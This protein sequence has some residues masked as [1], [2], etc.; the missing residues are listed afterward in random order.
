MLPLGEVP[1]PS[2][3]GRIASRQAETGGRPC[4]AVGPSVVRSPGHDPAPSHTPTRARY[5]LP[6]SSPA[7]VEFAGLPSGGCAWP[8]HQPR[9]RCGWRPDDGPAQ[10]H[11][12]LARPRRSDPEAVLIPP[13]PV[14]LTTPA[15]PR[16]PGAGVDH[17][18]PPP[19]AGIVPAP[20][21][22]QPGMPTLSPRGH[23]AVALPAWSPRT[24]PTF[25]SAVPPVVQR[26]HR[27]TIP[28]WGS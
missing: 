8:R 13:L 3:G 14:P 16:R 26:R 19:A 27:T 15:S 21:A 28:V 6:A 2:G 22:W 11:V 17:L 5:R 20:I 10:H 25:V 18:V 4:R 24:R 23:A 1:L 9:R 7:F 12:T